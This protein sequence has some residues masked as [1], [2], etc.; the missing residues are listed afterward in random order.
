[1][2][3]RNTDT[4]IQDLIRSKL[5]HANQ[6]TFQ[7]RILSLL[8]LVLERMS[9]DN[10]S[11]DEIQQFHGKLARDIKNNRNYYTHVLISKNKTKPD[12]NKLGHTA[13]ILLMF[14][15]LHLLKLLTNNNI[16]EQDLFNNRGLHLKLHRFKEK[17]RDFALAY[18]VG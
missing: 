9:P 15:D 7:N 10:L 3:K 6:M 17:L 18:Y 2:G 1:M 8:D 4:D 11:A 13:D 16:A 14:M 5:Q 12:L